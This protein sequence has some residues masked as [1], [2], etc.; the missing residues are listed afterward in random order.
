MKPVVNE[1]SFGLKGARACISGLRNKEKYMEYQDSYREEYGVYPEL[2]RIH[3]PF[4]AK[5]DDVYSICCEL[6]KSGVW[7]ALLY[8]DLHNRYRRKLKHIYENYSR[9]WSFLITIDLSYRKTM[10]EIPQMLQGEHIVNGLGYRKDEQ[11]NYYEGTW[12]DGRF[13]YGLVYLADQ[14]VYFVGS[15]DESG[16]SE[17]RGV[18]A[19]LG[20]E[21]KNKRTVQTLA[22]VFKL[23]NGDLSL[24]NDIFLNN[25]AN[26]KNDEF[27]SMDS[28]VG[29][30]EDGYIEGTVINKEISDEIRIRWDKYKDG[31][32]TSGSAGW[33]MMPRI[34]MMFYVAI[35]YLFKFVHC[36]AFLITPLYYYFRRKNW[37]I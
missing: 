28:Y 12:Q 21:K 18:A 4:I 34:L 30:Y 29:R 7:G 19:D 13:V 2:D 25:L 26:I 32:K 8:H 35:W 37:K 16:Q 15:F 11:G 33:E 22:G 9:E 1:K 6:R 10:V 23:K 17:C 20:E 14:D 27:V 31:E 5:F 24:Y 36:S 3:N